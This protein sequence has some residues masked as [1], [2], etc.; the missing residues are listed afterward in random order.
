MAQA[1]YLRENRVFRETYVKSSFPAWKL[2]F[3]VRCCVFFVEPVPEKMQK[4]RLFSIELS[5]L[6]QGKRLFAC[7]RTFY[8]RET[9][10]L[11][12]K[13]TKILMANENSYNISSLETIE[14]VQLACVPLMILTDPK[15]II[16]HT[17]QT[18]LR[19]HF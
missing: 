1:F 3:F 6:P 16:P 13:I 2:M 19:S 4:L 12:R 14:T 5:V 10:F 11:L 17:I 7:N 18:S 15:K 9:R 8:L